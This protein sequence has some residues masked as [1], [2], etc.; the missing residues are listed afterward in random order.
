M[1]DTVSCLTLPKL[2]K[3][4][5]LQTTPLLAFAFVVLGRL[6]LHG[7]GIA[8]GLTVSPVCGADVFGCFVRVP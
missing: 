5:M 6:L 1:G 3:D 7:L 8:E 4:R 2:V